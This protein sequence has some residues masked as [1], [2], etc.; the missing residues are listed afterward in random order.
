[1]E[2]LLRISEAQSRIRNAFMDFDDKQFLSMRFN[3]LQDI[4]IFG[5]NIISK[6]SEF[7]E[8]P[9]ILSQKE[10][11]ETNAQFGQFTQRTAKC[12]LVEKLLCIGIFKALPVFP[13]LDLKDKLIIL[14][15]VAPALSMLGNCF[16]SY[17]L[18]SHTWMRK[19]G[20]YPMAAFSDQFSFRNDKKLFSL[21]IKS[22][23][24]PIEPFFR[25]GIVKEEF[26][27]ILA[28]LFSNSDIPGLSE[29]A[30]NI[31][32]IES[33]RYSKM[34][35]RYLQIYLGQDAGTKKYAECI[36][37][38]GNTFLAAKNFN[39]LI[40]YKEAFYKRATVRSMM[41]TCLKAII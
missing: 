11:Y 14:Q 12:V 23:N 22:F 29:T 3:S 25:I 34:L 30:R 24:K 4:L 40:T 13:K 38:I 36:H 15:F 9:N 33:F 27:L 20:S 6:S 5:P 41:P 26:C 10:F 1:M 32:S 39:L 17:E 18:G 37:L 16:V 35:L 19:D 28:L 31:L 21:A 7:S 2:L 8:M